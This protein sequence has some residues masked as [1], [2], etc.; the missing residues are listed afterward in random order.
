MC[1]CVCVRRSHVSFIRRLSI[2]LSFFF[3]LYFYFILSSLSLASIVVRLNVR[4][5]AYQFTLLCLGYFSFDVRCSQFLTHSQYSYQ[6]FFCSFFVVAEQLLNHF[7]IL[8]QHTFHIVHT[9]LRLWRLTE[10]LVASHFQIHFF[11]TFNT[12][13][14]F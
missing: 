8:S 10:S 1:V 6:I 4:C 9:S 2:V 14:I 5:I 7:R 12:H 3:S 13:N 11:I